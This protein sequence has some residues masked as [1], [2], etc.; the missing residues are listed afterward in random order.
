MAGFVMS[1]ICFLPSNHLNALWDS[2]NTM[3]LH[4]DNMYRT[5]TVASTLNSWLASQD[6][7]TCFA[8]EDSELNFQQY[9]FRSIRHHQQNIHKSSKIRCKCCNCYLINLASYIVGKLYNRRFSYKYLAGFLASKATDHKI[10]FRYITIHM[11]GS[12]FMKIM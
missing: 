5:Q 10:I 12:Y 9:A 2:T 8:F 11:D 3:G 1:S 6:K 4:Y 7:I